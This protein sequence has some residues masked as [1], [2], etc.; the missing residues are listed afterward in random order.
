M[1]ISSHARAITLKASRS[2]RDLKHPA[3]PRVRQRKIAPGLGQR[4]LLAIA[5]CARKRGNHPGGA[6]N[7]STA[8]GAVRSWSLA[9]ASGCIL[10]A[11]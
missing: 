8:G 10:L 11:P 2:R 6:V 4:M 5:I 7:V 3:L 1:R 9:R